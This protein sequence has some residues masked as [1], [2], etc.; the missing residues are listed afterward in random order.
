MLKVFPEQVLIFNLKENRPILK[1]SQEVGNIF[2]EKQVELVRFY[3]S[4]KHCQVSHVRKG[5]KKH[6]NGIP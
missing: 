6:F 1:A 5:K 2:G 4:L 3:S